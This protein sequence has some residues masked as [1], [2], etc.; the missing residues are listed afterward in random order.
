VEAAGGGGGFGSAQIPADILKKF[1]KNQDGQLD[2]KEQKAAGDALGPKKSR[3]EKLQEKLDLNGDG[4]ITKEER[5]TVAAQ[6]KAEQ[7]ALKE[8]K[9]A[10][11]E[12]SR[13]KAKV[14]AADDK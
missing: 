11:L 14:K 1:D 6:Y 4:K 12:A 13:A 5:E 9:K 3:K 10:E 7:E 2:E 8:Q